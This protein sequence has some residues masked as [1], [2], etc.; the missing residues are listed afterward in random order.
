M[1]KITV[2]VKMIEH[3][4]MSLREDIFNT[5]FEVRS[6]NKYCFELTHPK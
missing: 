1:I 6:Q 5:Y 3:T 4:V 2:K